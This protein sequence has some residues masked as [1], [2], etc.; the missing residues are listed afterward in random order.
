MERRHFLFREDMEDFVFSKQ[1][2]GHKV[3]IEADY[4]GWRVTVIP[5]P[6]DVRL[7]A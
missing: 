5:Y 6:F 2:K 1:E 3:K 4:D 7:A